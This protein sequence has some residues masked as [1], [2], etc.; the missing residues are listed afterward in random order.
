MKIQLR[1]IDPPPHIAPPEPWPEGLKSFT[2]REFSVGDCWYATANGTGGWTVYADGYRHAIYLNSIA[3]EHV[4]K[5]PMIV[6]VPGGGGRGYPWCVHSRTQG[7]AG[8]GPSGW[9]VGG[10][11][12][13]ITLHPSVNMGKVWHG[14]IKSGVLT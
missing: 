4:G 8:Y 11:L 12:P 5:R 14:W 3:P 10:D 13:N 7:N 6:V 2:T 1:L 9:T